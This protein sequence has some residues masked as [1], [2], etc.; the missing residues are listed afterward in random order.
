M[1]GS[2]RLSVL[3]TRV[4]AVACLFAAGARGADWPMWR[5]D[6][7]RSAASPE[8]LPAT[9]RLQ[10][11]RKLPPL[12]PAWPDEPRMRF[13]VAYQPVVQGAT[14]FFGS[15]RNDT[16]TAL[17]ADTGAERWRFYADGPVRFAP[18]AAGGKVYFACDD[19]FL[20]CL[21][22][23]DGA[24]AW[25]LRGGP[26]DRRVLGNRRLISTWP[27]RGAPLLAD[28]TLY[29]AA[30]IWPFMGVFL[31]ALA[32]DTGQPVWQNDGMS[33]MYHRQPH[34]SPAF[35]GVAP[36]GYLA[37]S[38]DK[39][40]LPNGRAVP[41]CFE[42]AT[43]KFLYYHLSANGKRGGYDVSANAD[44]FFNAGMMFGLKDGAGRGTVGRAPVVTDDTVYAAQG[45][46]IRTYGVK[47]LKSAEHT[48]SRGRKRKRW[49]MTKRWEMRARRRVTAH[50]RAGRR[51]YV[52]SRGWVQAIQIPAEGGEPTIGWQ[53]AIAGTPG[54]MLAAGGKLFVVTLEGHLYCF[55]AK[56]TEAKMPEI[57]DVVV[58]P[59]GSVWK[60]LDDGSDQGRAW[61]AP[62][63]DD[64]AWRA[65]PA[66]LGYGN[67]DEA[68]VV[69]YGPDKKRKFITTYFRHAFQVDPALRLTGA[70]LGVLVDD[71]AVVYL[72][73][74]EVCRPG[75]PAS[76]V[77]HHG[78][79]ARGGVPEDDF[80]WTTLAPSLLAPGTNV[81]AVEVHQASA[82]SSDIS[83]DLELVAVRKSDEREPEP[84]RP[85]ADRWTD[86]AKRIL[87]RTGRPEGYCLV[88]G[89]GTGRLAEEL[90]R[91]S[92][93]H[94][95]A[96]DPDQSKID[97]LRRRLDDAGLYGVR[98]A[99]HKGDPLKFPFPPYLASLIA[100]EDLGAAGLD[101]GRRF[102]Q[103][104]FHA[105][106]PYG[107]TACLRVGGDEGR[108]LAAAVA[109]AKLPNAELDLDDGLARLRR[110]G[111]LPDSAD[112][113]HQYGDA[114][115]TV[116][117]R[118]KRVKA[119]LGLLWFG[120][121]SN[122]AVLPR[123]GH[124]PAEHVVGGRVIIEGPHGLRAT[125]VYTGRVLWQRELPDLGRP[126]DNTNHQPG[127][128]AIGSNYVSLS[129]AIYVAYG[130]N[131]LRLDPASGA[132]VAE[133]EFSASLV[134]EGP[135]SISFLA[136][137]GDLLLAGGVPVS[138]GEDFEPVEEHF[139]KWDEAALKKAAAWV[140]RLRGVELVSLPSEPDDG[141]GE[142][143]ELEPPPRTTRKPRDDKKKES[144]EEKERKEKA[145][146]RRKAELVRFLVDNLRRLLDEDDVLSKLPRETDVPQR[147]VHMQARI[148]AYARAGRG[149]GARSVGLRQ[150]NRRLLDQ[151]GWPAP[152]MRRGLFGAPNVWSGTTSKWLVAM[153]RHDGRVLWTRGA[154]HGFHHNAVVLGDAKVFCVD[155]LPE[156]V[157]RSLRRRGRRP[158]AAPKLL[159]LDAASG[160]VLWSRHEGV[161]GTWLGYSAEHDVLFHGARASRDMLAEPGTRM[162]AYRG[163]D[164]SLIWS[165]ERRYS[166]PCMLHG[167]TLITQDAAFSLLTG[168]ART[169]KNPLTGGD[170][171]WRLTRNYGCNTVIAS[172]HLLTFRSASAG[173]YDLAA[174]G[175]TGNLGGF[176]SGCTSNLI[177]ANG[178][179]N[180]PDYT[181]TCTCSYHNQTS[182]ALIHDPDVHLWTF[183]RLDVGKAPIKR[184]ALNLGAPGDHMDDDGTLWLE[185]PIVGGPS[186][187]LKVQTV[188]ERIQPFR[189]H[190]TWAD[191]S[192]LRWVAASGYIGLESLAVT[193]RRP[194][195]RETLP[196]TVR[197][198]FAEPEGLEPGERLFTVVMQGD[199]VLASLD[200]AKAARGP[201]RHLAKTFRNIQVRDKLLVAF[202]PEGA[203]GAVLCGLEVAAQGW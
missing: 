157:L 160:S 91:Q 67:K 37:A 117:S 191:K 103:R 96:V 142:D 138:Y 97:A 162:A 77:V 188:P 144:K 9:L 167:D 51:L 92:K 79:R 23:R 124:G 35:D 133:L 152:P 50:I 172:E 74:K 153:N 128:N 27:V 29:V 134:S 161:F 154:E 17:D 24:L 194:V 175:G 94:V 164:G 181:R 120:G 202:K 33:A 78:T 28:G 18:V 88:L 15:S 32:P 14:L 38:G 63:F 85:P 46:H 82:G 114:A 169:V 25:R 20:Y 113:T 192:G 87:A 137:D 22:A 45:R 131:I 69:S 118:D 59:R 180:A 105:L 132:T 196:Y 48:D 62:G 11:V 41:A 129:D 3:C 135:P 7:R 80:V 156:G 34:G 151:A 130:A 61:R 145:A 84:V 200:V 55:G 136:A 5:Y 8:E 1:H 4:L 121:S 123:H 149:P 148:R 190:P 171:P 44:N 140:R 95:I 21:D 53:A 197:L 6:A 165:R 26:S 10:W 168:E 158:A 86:E 195:G 66:E 72:N 187:K 106:R 176:K 101:K 184:L 183:N 159:A 89:V 116:V 189:H 201:R 36:Q 146:A 186:P 30:G 75:M 83:F 150:L 182:L 178:V 141:N 76:V 71:G 127:A 42:R 107:G 70:D 115:N 203:R 93:L 40:L 81:L 110:A 49:R 102:V 57:P 111:A 99:A 143:L 90:A 173:F 19:G 73:G 16:L 52:G 170:V 68:T 47:S 177:V 174:G 58:V 147:L 54:A 122:A 43:G 104:L 100:S 65:G 31:H 126:Y 60:Y 109:R 166:G 185:Y 193:L 13:D 198:H 125:D 64:G 2:R 179:L 12:A 155:R 119:P 163:K 39:L 112:W 56:P 108:A 199:E 98:V 139:E